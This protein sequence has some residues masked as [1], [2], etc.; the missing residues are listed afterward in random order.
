EEEVGEGVDTAADKPATSK[1]QRANRV[2]R[3]RVAGVVIG[4]SAIAFGIVDVDDLAR[5]TSE[6]SGR[7][8]CAFGVRT[9]IDG[10]G[11]GVIR[12][13]LEPMFRLLMQGDLQA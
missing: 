2:H 4:G 12:V 13:E 11:K 8:P 6:G 7:G 5:I 1:G 3:Y 9:E 10:L